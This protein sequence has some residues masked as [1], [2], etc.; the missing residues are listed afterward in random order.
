L[1]KAVGDLATFL[2]E[3]AV[4]KVRQQMQGEQSSLNHV[5]E[6]MNDG[7]LI[8]EAVLRSPEWRRIAQAVRART[9]DAESARRMVLALLVY[10][11]GGWKSVEA[12]KLFSGVDVLAL[13]RLLD[14]FNG[15]A[16]TA[17]E[18][19]IYRTVLAVGGLAAYGDVDG[20]LAACRRVLGRDLMGSERDALI[21]KG[22]L[23]DLGS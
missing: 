18:T 21:T 11:N 16:K 2:R 5:N 10:K 13:S 15:V 23:Y 4:Q 14:V 20:Y 7:T 17:G 6:N 8:K 19:R 3:K 1:D 22:K 12:S 9:P